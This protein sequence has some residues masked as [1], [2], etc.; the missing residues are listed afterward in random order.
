MTSFLSN[1]LKPVGFEDS[2]DF[3]TAEATELR[4][5]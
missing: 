1:K 4:Q 5:S 2:A 3:A